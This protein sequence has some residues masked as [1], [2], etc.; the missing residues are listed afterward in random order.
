MNYFLCFIIFIN[1]ES[2]VLRDLYFH[3]Q[4]VPKLYFNH[5]MPYYIFRNY[6]MRYSSIRDYLCRHNLKLQVW[7]LMYAILVSKTGCT[8]GVSQP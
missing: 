1:T 5:V 3:N 6:R 4:Y 2:I 8:E 7:E